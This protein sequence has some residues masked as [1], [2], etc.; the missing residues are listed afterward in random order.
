MS[1]WLVDSRSAA[2]FGTAATLGVTQIA[3]AAV[4]LAEKLEPA[5]AHVSTP[6]DEAYLIFTSGST[7]EPK[8]IVHTHRSASAYVNAAAS[9]HG[10]VV[11]D[12][13]AGMAPLHFDMSTL[14]LYVAPA[15]GAAVAPVPDGVL[16]F[17]ASVLDHSQR[18]GCTVWY[19]VPTLLRSLISTGEVSSDRLMSLRL[20]AYAGE[21][22]SPSV[23]AELLRRLPSTRL[24]NAYGPA[25]TNVVSVFDVQERNVGGASIPLGMPWPAARFEVREPT[26]DGPGELWLASETLMKGYLGRDDLT[27]E[28]VRVDDHGTRW[29]RTGDIVEAGPDGFVFLGR[30]DHQVKIK[31]VRLELEALEAALERHPAIDVAVIAAIPSNSPVELVVGVVGQLDETEL[32]QAAASL[33]P[34]SAHPTAWHPLDQLP[35]TQSGKIDRSRIRS[36]LAQR[37]K[38]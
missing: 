27:S 36:D 28:R 18:F 33:L 9:A 37:T 17:P 30:T 16:R 20:V 4:D 5:P 6:D 35:T 3:I 24:Q 8:G 14:E 2:R 21:P 10:L 1:F 26:A 38:N 12:V 23:A 34:P 29:Y 32:R 7:D 19:L 11:G 25:E 31:G 22:L 15:V 13:L